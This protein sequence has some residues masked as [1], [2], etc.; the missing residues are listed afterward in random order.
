MESRVHLFSLVAILYSLCCVFGR[1]RVWRETLP[2][3]QIREVCGITAASRRF[4][5]R[6][7]VS[8]SSSNSH[9]HP[10]PPY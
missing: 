1:V 8:R 7:A 4:D 2:D 3:F 6:P 9:C 10:L 5:R